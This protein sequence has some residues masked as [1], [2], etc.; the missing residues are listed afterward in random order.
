[1]RKAKR[2]VLVE[3]YFDAMRC[4][5]AGAQNALAPCGTALTEEQAKLIARYVSEAVVVFDGDAAGVKA[6]S[7]SIA[8]LTAAGLSVFA[9][10]L[11]EGMDPDDFIQARGAEAFLQTVEEARDFVTF[12]ARANAHRADTIEGRT[13]IARELFAILGRMNDP[14]RCDEYL[15]R[16]AGELKLREWT[17]R[18]EFSRYQNGA[19]QREAVRASAPEV[20]GEERSRREDEEVL[21]VVLADDAWR[22]QALRKLEALAGAYGGGLTQDALP[23]AALFEALGAV[24]EKGPEVRPRDI[25]SEA[26]QRLLTAAAALEPPKGEDREE[27]MRKRLT[28][29]EYE[30]L[31]AEAARLQQAIREAGGPEGPGLEELLV[32]KARVASQMKAVAAGR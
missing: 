9:A 20:P 26:A 16:L 10:V 17:V 1:L 22:A 27:R 23:S 5:E 32:R 8:V 24:A 4:H 31:R 25:E 28:A 3:G 7:R 18:Q 12:Y 2:A 19:E 11:P 29:L 21:A 14:M 13:Q 6:A 30:V 15:R